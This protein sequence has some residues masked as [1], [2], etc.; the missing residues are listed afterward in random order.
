MLGLVFLA[1]LVV[2][3][4]RGA[5][6][7]ARHVRP[8]LSMPPSAPGRSPSTLEDD[9][10]PEEESRLWSPPK[11]EI[12]RPGSDALIDYLLAGSED[13][14]QEASAVDLAQAI[15]DAPP[16]AGA[17]RRLTTAHAGKPPPAEFLRV[18]RSIPEF[19]NLV[20]RFRSDPGFQRLLARFA[21]RRDVQAMMR[22]ATLAGSDARPAASGQRPA[23]TRVTARKPPGAASLADLPSAFRLAGTP[24]GSAGER[25]V[26]SAAEK[27][28]SAESMENVVSMHGRGSREEIGARH[29]PT[30]R[31]RASVTEAQVALP[32]I[33][34]HD[35]TPGLLPV[36][37]A[38]PSERIQR[39]LEVYPWLASL[40]PASLSNLAMGDFIDRFGLWGGC[41]Y[42]RIWQ[43]CQ[44]AC[45]SDVRP[46]PAKCEF[47][48]P[49]DSC[50]EWKDST[51]DPRKECIPQCLSQ[52]PCQVPAAV[53]EE[54]CVDR[55]SRCCDQ[56]GNCSDCP[57]C[58]SPHH[59][60][61]FCGP[62]APGAGP[63][64]PS[65]TPVARSTEPAR[66]IENIGVRLPGDLFGYAVRMPDTG[67]I[68][69]VLGRV[70]DAVYSQIRSQAEA[71][72]QRAFVETW[73]RLRDSGAWNN[74]S[75][76]VAIVAATAAAARETANRLAGGNMSPE[77]RSQLEAQ[78]RALEDYR[79]LTQQQNRIV[80]CGESSAD[81]TGA[82]P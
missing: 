69:A 45:L 61:R 9:A 80:R 68:G 33:R 17:W 50:L 39:L 40:Q 25:G 27:R 16:L 53:R 12:G 66:A 75:V 63:P 62:L 41:F 56:D 5:L 82:C 52:A 26:G 29:E 15:L 8:S 24:P 18:M 23:A 73:T 57:P 13:E 48:P 43:E 51:S 60:H 3:W 4:R 37:R 81:A 22:G 64:V 20:A 49:W 10:D 36:A 79:N 74:D 34:A 59:D 47:S 21:D 71:A 14:S 1:L 6:L 31:V 54:Y 38:G 30:Q 46:A 2:L 58:T 28:Y 42:L 19:R 72:A 65:P 78:A 44:T 32:V 70:D 77:Q 7:P 67:A 76:V 11:T 55:W 35:V